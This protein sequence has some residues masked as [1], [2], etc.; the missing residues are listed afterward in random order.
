MTRSRTTFRPRPFL[1]RPSSDKAIARAGEVGRVRHAAA[2]LKEP[3]RFDLL[4]LEKFWR[5]YP[6]GNLHEL[7]RLLLDQSAS[8]SI[9][10]DDLIRAA[11]AVPLSL[12]CCAG[13][14]IIRAVKSVLHEDY[15]IEGKRLET[16]PEMLRLASQQVLSEWDVL[17]RLRKWAQ[18]NHVNFQ[19]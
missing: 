16:L 12:K 18:S 5:K 19:G 7:V 1:S 4:S 9:S 13:H 3:V 6:G 17:T 8:V 11:E 15:G 14:D 10:R 2:V